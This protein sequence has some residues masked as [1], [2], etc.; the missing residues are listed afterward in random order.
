MNR[1][2]FCC[3]I[4]AALTMSFLGCGGS[5]GASS[6]TPTTESDF[7]AEQE[8]QAEM[9]EQMKKGGDPSAPASP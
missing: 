4:C 2:V 9:I 5:P 1:S 6:T 8:K 7:E 3:V